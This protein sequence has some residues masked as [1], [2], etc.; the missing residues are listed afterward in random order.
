MLKCQTKVAGPG[1]R[2]IEY[3]Q[4]PKSNLTEWGPGMGTKTEKLLGSSSP[5]AA[6]PE[7][8]RLLW[9]C[10]SQPGVPVA[11]CAPISGKETGTLIPG[12]PSCTV[13]QSLASLFLGSWPNYTVLASRKEEGEPPPQ[14]PHEQYSVSSISTLWQSADH[15]C[16]SQHT[17][18]GSGL[19]G[20]CQSENYSN[21]NL[22]NSN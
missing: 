5:G 18:A 16:R 17:S 2:I 3:A 6:F 7:P 19:T 22:Q 11:R 21:R 9:L 20:F 4:H 8:R 13:L 12:W 15:S 14:C 10:P 1:P